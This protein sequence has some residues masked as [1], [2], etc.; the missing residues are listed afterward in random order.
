MS[1]VLV[2]YTTQ[3]GS[4]EEVAQAIAD[5]LSKAGLSVETRRLEEVATI[6]PYAA[7]VIGAPMI[8]GWH[9]AAM[10]FVKRHQ[11]AL[12]RRPVAYFLTAMRLTLTGQQTAQDV[13]LAI[14]PAL[15]M[16]PRNPDR[17]GLKE[18][19]ASPAHYAGDAL[20]AA[21]MVRPVSVAIFG[22]RLDLYKLKLL[23][24]LFVMAI[25]QAQPGDRRNW[26]FIRA[27]AAGLPDS[28][29]AHPG[30]TAV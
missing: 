30:W 18:R 5:E 28:F 10:K 26:P 6:E 29:R 1:N 15:A 16:P 25:I 11:A 19:Y 9:R 23:P 4:T 20:D 22:G 3:S 8:V 7:V 14:D 2:A 17:L 21:P 12:S 27:W 13:P 24:M